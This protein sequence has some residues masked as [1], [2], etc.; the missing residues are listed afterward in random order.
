[1][2]GNLS[3]KIITPT[4]V[5]LEESEIDSVTV[6]ASD[7]QI[8][9]LPGHIPLITKILAGE[10]V[11]QKKGKESSYVVTQGYLK[12]NKLGSITVLSDYAV[13]SE[14]IEI[15]K[16]EAAKKKAEEAM[17]QKSSDRDFV[18]AEAELRKTLL[19]LR[20]AKRRKA[21]RV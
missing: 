6:D 20:V 16:V 2:A 12:L 5:V 19:E 14:E 4:G 10:L 15:A 13:R 9:I 1:M 17:R 3:L 8:T 18:V 11:L 7:G 21:P